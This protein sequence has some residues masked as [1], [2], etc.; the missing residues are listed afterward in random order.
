MG[1]LQGLYVDDVGETL[2]TPF[3][4]VL[5]LVAHALVEARCLE[6]VRRENDLLAATSGSFSFSRTQQYGSQTLSSVPFVHPDV[7]KFTTSSPR[8][9]VEPRD[10]VACVVADAAAD[11]PSVEVSRCVRIEL[12]NAVRQERAELLAVRIVSTQGDARID[13]GRRGDATIGFVTIQIQLQ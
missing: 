13:A 2:R 11:Q 5:P 10:D 9:S 1:P 6:T 12:V 8:M 3:D 7:R 4:D